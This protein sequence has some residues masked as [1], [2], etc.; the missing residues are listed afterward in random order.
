MDIDLILNACL[1]A[2]M[3]GPNRIKNP[4]SN[5]IAK[6][7]TEWLRCEIEITPVIDPEKDLSNKTTLTISGDIQ[8]T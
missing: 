3:C 7:I 2:A 6:F 4:D 8:K 5:K 1:N